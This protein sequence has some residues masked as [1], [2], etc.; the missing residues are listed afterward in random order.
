LAKAED[1]GRPLPRVIDV[2][3]ADVEIHHCVRAAESRVHVAERTLSY[4]PR[5]RRA[6]AKPAP[7]PFDHREHFAARLTDDV[8]IRERVQTSAVGHE[9]PDGTDVLR[10]LDVGQQRVAAADQVTRVSEDWRCRASTLKERGLD[11]AG[12]NDPPVIQL[13]LTPLANGYASL[14]IRIGVA[15]KKAP[16]RRREDIVEMTEVNVVRIAGVEEILHRQ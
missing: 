12:W 16:D 2:N 9:T 1:P 10:T 14:V 3:E 13:A 4:L 7:T 15:N 8:L 5:R 11:D 6:H